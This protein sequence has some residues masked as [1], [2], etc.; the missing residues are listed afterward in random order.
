MQLKGAPNFWRVQESLQPHHSLFFDV[1]IN[2][3]ETIPITTTME[4][5]KIKKNIKPSKKTK[6]KG[7]KGWC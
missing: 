6:N 2:Q 7:F 3:P 4:E 1:V 5:K